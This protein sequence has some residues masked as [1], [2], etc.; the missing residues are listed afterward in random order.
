MPSI[1]E[2]HGERSVVARGPEPEGAV[3]FVCLSLWVGGRLIPDGS[4]TAP[5][6]ELQHSPWTGVRGTTG[7][8]VPAGVAVALAG[9][10]KAQRPLAAARAGD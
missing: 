6:Q 1:P 3:A 9:D 10:T 7:S 2:P 4:L 5:G 8:G